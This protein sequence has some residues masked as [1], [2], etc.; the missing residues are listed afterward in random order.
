MSRGSL[1]IALCNCTGGRPSQTS[2]TVGMDH[3]HMFPMRKKYRK[4]CYLVPEV[5]CCVKP[6]HLAAAYNRRI[7]V[8]STLDTSSARNGCKFL[9]GFSFWWVWGKPNK[10]KKDFL[11]SFA[12]NPIF[13]RKRNIGVCFLCTVLVHVWLSKL[14]SFHSPAVTGELA[15][16][17]QGVFHCTWN[18]Y[19]SRQTQRSLGWLWPVG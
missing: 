18:L 11:R 6:C 9:G 8:S 2:D 17:L 7:W 4:L 10:V 5:T 1:L 13:Q 16:C 3:S 15:I 12:L 14:A 19:L